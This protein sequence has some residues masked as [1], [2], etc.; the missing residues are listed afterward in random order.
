[1][2]KL[3]NS[4]LTYRKSHTTLVIHICSKFSFLHGLCSYLYIGQLCSISILATV[5]GNDILLHSI[6]SIFTAF[7]EA[8]KQIRNIYRSF[9]YEEQCWMRIWLHLCDMG[10]QSVYRVEMKASSLSRPFIRILNEIRLDRSNSIP[11]GYKSGTEM[12]PWFCTVS[13]HGAFSI[14]KAFRVMKHQVSL[15]AASGLFMIIIFPLNSCLLLFC[16][17]GIR[18]RSHASL[19]G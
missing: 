16:S 19:I 10:S 8:N 12:L 4:V 18:A 17:G 6:H 2:G 11:H 15:T 7:W 13:A 1:M 14:R 9:F 5:V 3:F